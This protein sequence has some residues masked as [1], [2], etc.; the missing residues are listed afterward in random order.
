MLRLEEVKWT[1]IE[2]EE[3]FNEEKSSDR[4]GDES[5]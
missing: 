3:G 2:M 4:Y 1:G 5:S